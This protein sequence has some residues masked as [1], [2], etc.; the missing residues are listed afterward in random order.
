MKTVIKGLTYLLKD[1][2]L[3]KLIF[4][5]L[6]VV[7]LYD[8]LLIF[9]IERPTMASIAKTALKPTN[10]PSI[11]I[12]ARSGFNQT[13]LSIL[14]YEHGY[15]YTRGF[16]NDKHFI[17]W[18]GN[19]SDLSQ[20]EVAVKISTIR[21]T[22]DCPRVVAIFKVDNKKVRRT[23]ILELTRGLYPSGQCCAAEIPAEAA[24]Y[25]VYEIDFLLDNQSSINQHQRIQNSS[26]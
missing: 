24:K 10:F 26:L 22:E 5:L 23:L 20:E 21:T 12:C 17:G 9:F 2:R 4:T 16:P 8:E 7:L 25:P 3:L 13:E 15:K 18:T 14:G 6:T 1:F 11:Y 19:Q